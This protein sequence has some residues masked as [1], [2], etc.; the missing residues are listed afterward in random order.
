MKKDAEDVW[1]RYARPPQSVKVVRVHHDQI[2]KDFDYY[3]VA[4]T[5]VWG[6]KVYAAECPMEGNLFEYYAMLLTKRIGTVVVISGHGEASSGRRQIDY[7][8]NIISRPLV[9]YG[10]RL[11]VG[12]SDMV[13]EPLIWNAAEQLADEPRGG[14]SVSVYSCKLTITLNYEESWTVK[15]IKLSGWPDMDVITRR[16]L[17]FWKEHI[18]RKLEQ[19]PGPLLVH[20]SAGRGR[21]GVTLGALYLDEG[22]ISDL[23]LLCARM[24][25][26]RGGSMPITAQQIAL[27]REYAE[28]KKASRRAPPQPAERGEQERR[29]RRTRCTV[30]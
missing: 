26:E 18:R 15:V 3:A 25:R 7:Y 11:R 23:D 14:A 29:S 5:P 28:Y 22:K 13:Q 6:H 27:L 8:R 16:K 2:G 17:S 19:T 4:M 20:C 10:A 24:S 9:K 21:T 12:V 30:S 1:H